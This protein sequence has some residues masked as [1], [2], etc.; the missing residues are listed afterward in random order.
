MAAPSFF[1]PLVFLA[2]PVAGQRIELGA[3]LGTVFSSPLMEDPIATAPTRQLLGG[4]VDTL[5]AVAP[6]PSLNVGAFARVAFWPRVALE[7]TVDWAHG[8]LEARED[9]DSR[10]LQSLSV[11]QAT[12]GASWAVRD[13]IQLGGAVGL[14]R[15]VTDERALFALGSDTSPLA[16][17]RGAWL[18]PVLDRRVGLAVRLHV[19]RF[20]AQALRNRGATDGVVMRLDGGLQ[21]RLAEI[22]R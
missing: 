17:V 3:R 13:A 21:V 1:I 6:G 22:G 11:L 16:E 4:A 18:P 14:L 10:D 20:G 8:D 19:H 2:T 12:V 5:V 9:G 7:G 15:Y